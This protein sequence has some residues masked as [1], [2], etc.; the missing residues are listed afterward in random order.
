MTVARFWTY[1]AS[2]VIIRNRGGTKGT[3]GKGGGGKG[4][5]KGKDTGGS[6][7]GGGG[8]WSG[9]GGK[10]G[11]TGGGGNGDLAPDVV[12]ATLGGAT[13]EFDLSDTT[14]NRYMIVYN[15]LLCSVASAWMYLEVRRKSDSTWEQGAAAYRH[16]QIRTNT[17]VGPQDQSAH[18]IQ[19]V[20]AGPAVIEGEIFLSNPSIAAPTMAMG[21]AW[22]AGSSEVMSMVMNDEIVHDQV[23]LRLD[24]GVFTSA[25][26]FHIVRME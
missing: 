2:E 14:F 17:A 24:S 5:G 7:D 13:A 3:G 22:S 12:A 1:T 21:R 16:F 26:A 10:G 6:G 20:P 8:G 11:P 19:Q 18:T 4:G 15:N 9:R 25:D 23:R